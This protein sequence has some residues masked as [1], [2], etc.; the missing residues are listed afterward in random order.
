ML[1]AAFRELVERDRAL[2]RRR[3]G[4]DTRDFGSD[5]T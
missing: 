4:Q 3:S 1:V 2:S 5:G